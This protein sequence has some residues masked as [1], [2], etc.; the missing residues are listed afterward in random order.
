MTV[1]CAECELASQIR[2]RRPRGTPS[3]ATVVPAVQELFTSHS[4]YGCPDVG[5]PPAAADIPSAVSRAHQLVT[6]SQRLGDVVQPTGGM[7][8]ASPIC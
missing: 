3:G 5:K 1:M 7:P 4:V 8:L 6:D 2:F